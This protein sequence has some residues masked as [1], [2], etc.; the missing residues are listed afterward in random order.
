MTKSMVAVFAVLAISGAVAGAGVAWLAEPP[1]LE[2]PDDSD[3]LQPRSWSLDTPWWERTIVRYPTTS[4][5]EWDIALDVE[6][7]YYG[8]VSLD[9]ACAESRECTRNRCWENLG[10]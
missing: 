8:P 5:E 7:P 6:Y 4:Y 9:F 10:L 2:S 3:R 1:S